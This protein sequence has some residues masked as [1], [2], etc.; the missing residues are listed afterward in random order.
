MKE[1]LR[2]PTFNQSREL[3]AG[4]AGNHSLLVCENEDD[5]IV[6]WIVAFRYIR[7]LVVR[8]PT[9]ELITWSPKDPVKITS[10][11]PFHFIAQTSLYPKRYSISLPCLQR[12]PRKGIYR[13]LLFADYRV[14]SFVKPS[15]VFTF[16]C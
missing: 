6:D 15:N 9:K 3:D 1:L 14:R 2:S 12:S 13:F 16:C 4:Y 5:L 10:L 8:S 11:W 7:N